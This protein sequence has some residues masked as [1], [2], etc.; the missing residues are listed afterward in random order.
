VF[1]LINSPAPSYQV[2]V[3]TLA[4]QVNKLKITAANL[5]RLVLG[6]INNAT[7]SYQA[8]AATVAKQVNNLG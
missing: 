7:P 5:S 2:Y 6:L 4:K 1:G 8:Y 3:A